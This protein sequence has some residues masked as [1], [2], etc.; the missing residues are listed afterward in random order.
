[1]N[2][3]FILNIITVTGVDIIQV[4]EHDD[5]GSA[6]TTMCHLWLIL[7]PHHCCE[8]CWEDEP[9]YTV[10]IVSMFQRRVS[11][12]EALSEGLCS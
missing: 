2:Q 5:G 8:V 4:L 12:T 1:M 6:Y 3:V 11:F 10:A 9:Q 7:M